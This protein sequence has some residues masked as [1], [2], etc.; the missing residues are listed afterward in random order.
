MSIDEVK[1]FKRVGERIK[2]KR[3]AMGFTLEEIAQKI[4]VSR[5]TMSRYET[6]VID[7][8]S[9][10]R[11]D[12]I[13]RALGTT[14]AA[15]YGY[16]DD[17]SAERSSVFRDRLN[18]L[19]EISD[20]TD[21]IASFGTATPYKDILDG[22]LPITLDK[23]SEIADAFGVPLDY[24]IGISTLDI[25]KIQ[26]RTEDLRGEHDKHKATHPTH[27]ASEINS[28]I[29]TALTHHVETV[30]SMCM[31]P[32]IRPDAIPDRINAA[33]EYLKHGQW[34]IDGNGGGKID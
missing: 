4:G 7:H 8:I 1:N 18:D 32:D 33:T 2:E 11:I 26:R 23:A 6:G 29:E 27:P 5:Q 30:K 22:T 34:F 20:K 21:M 31:R 13:A 24:L 10:A 28:A 16:I 19:I 17:L 3:L 9:Q 25:D 15:L 12:D 14:G